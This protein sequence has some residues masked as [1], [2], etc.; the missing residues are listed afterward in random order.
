MENRSAIPSDIRRQILVEAGHRCAIQTCRSAAYIDIHHIVPWAQ[1]QS[2]EPDNLIALCPNC[3]RRADREEIDR[4]SL[5]NYKQI[6]QALARPP[7]T[8]N[9]ARTFIK[10]S[11]KSPTSILEASN[12]TSLIDS[13]TLKF[14]FGFAQP[15]ED[16]NYV[17]SASGNGSVSFRTI[18]QTRDTMHVEFNEPCPEIVKIEFNE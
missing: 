5:R 3:H 9:E 4:K 13:G 8:H 15:F 14:G 2:H 1:S 6:C 10:F 11:P 7:Q 16:A 17:A 12:I 18:L